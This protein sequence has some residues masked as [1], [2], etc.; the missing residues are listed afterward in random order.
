MKSALILLCFGLSF[1]NSKGW[2]YTNPTFK[3]N[4]T[5][6]QL[7]S[8]SNKSSLLTNTYWSLDPFTLVQRRDTNQKHTI[9]F[10]KELD[11]KAVLKSNSSRG[12]VFFG[13]NNYY[14]DV[15]PHCGVTTNT[16]DG[17]WYLNENTIKIVL[18]S[19]IIRQWEIVQLD[20]E[21][22]IIRE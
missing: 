9:K 7:D 8:T 5:I 18:N 13:E 16:F 17:H 3:S 10:H 6:T 15:T 12:G 22:L 20:S 11:S 1:W 21:L 19:G 4:S 2:N 14:L